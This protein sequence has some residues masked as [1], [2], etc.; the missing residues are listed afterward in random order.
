MK[1]D[2]IGTNGCKATV[3]QQ[4]ID[5][6]AKLEPTAPVSRIADDL[7]LNLQRAALLLTER[8][9]LR[10]AVAAHVL[11]QRQ[12]AAELERLGYFKP[13]AVMRGEWDEL[14]FE[15]AIDSAL[16]ADALEFADEDGATFD[17]TVVIALEDWTTG[18]ESYVPIRPRGHCPITLFRGSDRHDAET[19]DVD[20][21]ACGEIFEVNGRPVAVFSVTAEWRQ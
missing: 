10:A 20:Y 15:D 6:P 8:M 19:R 21:R 1:L 4:A 9:R 13:H 7:N 14:A 16:Q 2:A 5:D 12:V 11:A 17:G 18:D 3:W